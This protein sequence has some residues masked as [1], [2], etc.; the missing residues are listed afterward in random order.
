MK[1]KYF[2]F[3]FLSFYSFFNAFAQ[4]IIILKNEKLAISSVNYQIENVKDG[5][6]Q[7]G[8]IGSVLTAT[9]QKESITLNGG[10][11]NAVQGF[12]LKNLPRQTIST[13]I[14]YNIKQLMLSESKN[15]NGFIAGNISLRVSFERISKKDTVALVEYSAGTT[16]SRSGGTPSMDNYEVSLR[17]LL[18]ESMKYFDDWMKLNAGRHQALVKGVKIVFLPDFDKNDADTIYYGTR[19]VNWDDFRGKPTNSRF[20]AAIFTSFGYG[21]SF[22]VSGGLIQANVQTKVYMVRGMS[23]VT[24]AAREDYSLAHEQL[25]FDITYLVV[26]RFR[27]KIAAMQAETVDDLNSMIQYEYLESYREMNKLQ[28]DYDGESN[29]SLNQQKQAEWAGKVKKWLEEK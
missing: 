19:K 1:N 28:N 12:L 21:A 11:K 8:N 27:K 24:P 13:K 4:N 9:G 7:Q 3:I 14:Q 17:K 29:H 26:E 10:V 2:L 25:H 15:G 22:R 5:R 18:T 6:L 23:W 16:F 20:G